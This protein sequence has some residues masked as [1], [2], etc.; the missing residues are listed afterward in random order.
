MGQQ[1]SQKASVAQ[2]LTT[3][4][5]HGTPVGN[6]VCG[7]RPSPRRDMQVPEENILKDV[8]WNLS[9]QERWCLKKNT[10]RKDLGDHL[11]ICPEY[12]EHEAS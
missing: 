8:G 6:K 1:A 7:G 2:L 3:P 10:E 5:S 4:P 9:M 12:M 11:S